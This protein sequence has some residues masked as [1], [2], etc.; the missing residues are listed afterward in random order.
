M[1]EQI[2]PLQYGMLL[3][4]VDTMEKEIH[5][6]RADMVKLLDLAAQGRGG[7]WAGMLFVSIVSS[8]AGYIVSLWGNK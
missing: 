3:Q 7:F 1:S 8:M 4:K 2:D 5:Q 6:L